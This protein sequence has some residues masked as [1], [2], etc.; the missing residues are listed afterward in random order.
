MTG[1]AGSDDMTYVKLVG[2]EAST[3]FIPID[4]KAKNNWAP[5]S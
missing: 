5:H 4:D 2:E 3:G 1:A